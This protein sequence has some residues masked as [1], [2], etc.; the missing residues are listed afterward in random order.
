MDMI[1]YIIIGFVIIVLMLVGILAYNHLNTKLKY[2]CDKTNE[3]KKNVNFRLDDYDTT[4]HRLE[5]IS[6]RQK[7]TLDKHSSQIKLM[8]TKVFNENNTKQVVKKRSRDSRGNPNKIN[9][10]IPTK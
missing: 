3:T 4:L 1:G 10:V 6:V 9:P 2:H 5:S 8:N 7:E